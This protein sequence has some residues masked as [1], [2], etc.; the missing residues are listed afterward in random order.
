VRPDTRLA[1]VGDPD[2]LACVEA[3]AVLADLVDGL[4]ERDD[5]N[6]GV[7]LA[8]GDFAADFASFRGA[9]GALTAAI[10]AG[11]AD[12]AVEVLRAGGEHIEWIAPGSRPRRYAKSLCRMHFGYDS[13]QF[14]P[15]R[16]RHWPRSTSIGYCVRTAAARTGCNTGIGMSNVG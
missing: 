9:I 4:A 2:Q 1:L 11:D 15:T 16:Q 14:W 8:V 6:R 3:G 7:G 12:R 5:T 13:P 10:R